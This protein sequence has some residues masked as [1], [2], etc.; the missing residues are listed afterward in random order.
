LDHVASGM[1]SGDFLFHDLYLIFRRTY[2]LDRV[3]EGF[4]AEDFHA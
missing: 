3:L 2:V 4:G 1:V